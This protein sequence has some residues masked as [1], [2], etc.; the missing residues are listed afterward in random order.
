MTCLLSSKKSDEC[1]N[2]VHILF[3]KTQIDSRS[4]IGRASFILE[5]L[6]PAWGRL[7]HGRKQNA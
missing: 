5:A 4:Q 6:S 3:L 7:L 2:V 1:S